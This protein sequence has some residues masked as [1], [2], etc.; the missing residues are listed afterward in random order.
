[1]SWNENRHIQVG[2][3]GHIGLDRFL[4]YQFSEEIHFRVVSVAS[5]DGNAAEWKLGI[6]GGKSAD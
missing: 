2:T 3:G 1:M 6:P 5:K 4:E